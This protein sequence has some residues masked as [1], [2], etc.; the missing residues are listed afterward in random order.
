MN[1]PH[2]NDYSSNEY[3]TE[4]HQAY[5]GRDAGTGT[6]DPADAQTGNKPKKKRRWPW[7]V[8]IFVALF[9]GVG[10]GNSG[11]AEPEVVTETETE[12]V[13]EEVEV[14]VE[15]ADLQDRRDVIAE[16]EESLEAR[17]SELD[18]REAALDEREAEL[19]SQAQADADAA[20]EEESQGTSSG[21][22]PGSGTF[23]IG[24][25]IQP[26]T[27]RT[28]GDSGFCYWA[29]LSGLSGELGDIITNDLPDGPGFVTI[30]ET[31]VAFETTDCGEWVAQ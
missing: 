4:Q 13:T 20:E 7:I 2:Q 9:V 21:S 26:G 5:P 17:A 27:Y 12:T 1:H 14:E 25:D 23:L 18:D 28:E 19:E 16:D 6:Q 8:G 10:I 31:D 24:E 30:A 11:D 3:P 22:I 15:P 29:R